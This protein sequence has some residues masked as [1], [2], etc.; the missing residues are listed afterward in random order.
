MWRTIT[1]ASENDRARKKTH[2]R[3]IRQKVMNTRQSV[4]NR[5]KE[6]GRDA[7]STRPINSPPEITK[8]PFS[9]HQITNFQSAPCHS[10]L[11]AKTSRT[12]YRRFHGVVRFPPR[13]R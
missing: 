12:L 8:R 9:S 7:S 5:G 10:P 2:V 1:T 3:Q 11:N 13:G 4:S 6:P